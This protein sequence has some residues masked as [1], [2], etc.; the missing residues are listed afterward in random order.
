MRSGV[1]RTGTR[2]PPKQPEA[3]PDLCPFE[4][5]RTASSIRTVPLVRLA[6]LIQWRR[7][8]TAF[9][10]LYTDRIGRAD[11][12]TRLMIVLRML[13]H[14]DGLSDPV[15]SCSA[16]GQVQERRFA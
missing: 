8:E 6:K 4:R 7:I 1:P 15:C 10:A 3:S 9:G 14:R 13:K 2:L 12:P 16:T 11:R 5:H